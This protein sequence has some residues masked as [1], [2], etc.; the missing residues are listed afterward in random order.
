[1]A[2]LQGKQLRFRQRYFA[3]DQ[4]ELGEF[5]RDTQELVGRIPQI[6]LRIT[7][8]QYME[9][10]TLGNMTQEPFCIELVRVTNL[11]APQTPQQCG[12]MVHYTWLPAQNGC[13]IASIDGMST[14]TDRIPNF[15][16]YWRISYQLG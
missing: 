11:L 13:V 16:F 15:R 10:M 2:Q 1:M 8:Q 12:G 4:T 3:N 14:L 9:P 6:E 5:A 7:E